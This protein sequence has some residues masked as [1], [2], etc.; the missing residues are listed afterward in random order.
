MATPQYLFLAWLAFPPIKLLHELGHGLAVRHWGG[1]VHEAGVGLFVLTPAPYVDASASAGFRRRRQRA[2]VAAIGIM[3]EFA[4]AAMA[5]LVW[6]NIQPGTLRDLAFVTMTV[7]SVSTLV[8]NANPLLQFDGY[9]VLCDVLDLPNLGTRSRR[10]WVLLLQRAV[11]GGNGPRTLHAM[12]GEG[13]WLFAYAPAAA[14]YRI[15]LSGMIVLWV[16]KWSLVLGVL[17]AAYVLLAALVLPA[18]ALARAVLDAAPDAS[19]RGRGRLAVASGVA[20]CAF[21]TCLMPLPFRTAA[22][23]VVWLP[24]HAQARPDTDGFITQLVAHDGQ[25]VMPGQLLLRL[26]DPALFAQRDKLNSQLAGLQSDR[27][28]SL[29]RDSL[30]AGNLEE[31]MRRVAGELRRAE[32]RIAQLEVRS[33]VAGTFVMPAQQDR[34]GTWV[35]R[36]STLGYI[37]DRK[38][39]GVRAA[40]PERDAALIRQGTSRVE[41]RLAESVPDATFAGLVREVPAAVHELPSAALGDRGGGPFVTD[42]ADQDGVRTLAPIVLIDLALPE[43]ALERIGGRVWVRFDHGSQTLATQAWRRMRQLFLQH[44]NPA[45]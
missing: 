37:L 16:G 33:Q 31:E 11:F 17:V 23:G 26:D 20:A 45:G 4:L 3:V 32:E 41:V 27:F 24:E 14:L 25:R 10:F 1:E 35:K 2:A 7:A 19:Q 21:F 8:F 29:A 6:L 39:I 22:W 15:G 36:G 38:E 34:L 13:K 43:R 5:L 12:A 40:V 9:H 18:I 42:P 30:K 28:D 44:F